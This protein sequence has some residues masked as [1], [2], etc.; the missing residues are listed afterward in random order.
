MQKDLYPTYSVGEVTRFIKSLFDST[1]D[2]QNICVEGEISN[3]KVAQSGHVYFTIKDEESQ[4]SCIQ[5]RR[6]RAGQH[7]FPFETGDQVVVRGNFSVYLPYGKYQFYVREVSAAGKGELYRQFL[8]LKEQLK[9]EGLFDEQFKKPLPYMPKTIG[10]VTSS[11]G[12]VVHDILRTVRKN[13]PPVKIILAPAQV[14]GKEAAEDMMQKLDWLDEHEE[15]ELIVLARGGGSMEDL[16]P[17][18]EE[19]LARKIF[20]MKKPLISAVGHETDFSISDFV[21]DLRAPTPTAAAERSVPDKKELIEWLQNS[22]SQLGQQILN[23]IDLAKMQMDDLSRQLQ[24]AISNI[25]SHKKTQLRDYHN[26]IGKA[27]LEKKLLELRLNMNSHIKQKISDRKYELYLQKLENLQ[28]LK[29]KLKKEENRQVNLITQTLN[30]YRKTIELQR[31]RIQNLEVGQTLSRGFSLTKLNGNTLKSTQQISKG[32]RITTFLK[33][34]S[35]SAV[36][37]NKNSKHSSNE[38]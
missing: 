10:V 8:M 20:D 25:I 19:P 38:Q 28:L 7:N 14:Q 9:E 13:F 26:R 24:N 34:G 6:Y 36:V 21:A 4:L 17:F 35:F 37:Q 32:D 12:A 18:N 22:G 16:W 11:S 15:T 31:E 30:N 27:N 3:L 23:K 1:S 2:L 29:S 33:E 5:F